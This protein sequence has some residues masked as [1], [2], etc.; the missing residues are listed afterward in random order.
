MIFSIN[1]VCAVVSFM[2]QIYGGGRIDIVIIF[3]LF[4]SVE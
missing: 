4:D 3:K 1:D 2:Y